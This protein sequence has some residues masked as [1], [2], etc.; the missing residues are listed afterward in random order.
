MDRRL[1]TATLAI[2]LLLAAL[3][4]VTAQGQDDGGGSTEAEG[5]A[6]TVFDV[7][8][9]Q[10]IDSM[11]PLIGVTVAAYEA[12]NLQYATLTDKAADDFSV[13]P[14][15][16]ESWEGSDDGKTWTYKLRPNLKWSDGEPLTAEDI[17]WNDQHLARRGVAQPLGDHHQPDG[18]GA[19]R[20][21]RRHQ[22]EGA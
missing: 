6:Q 8:D 21:H 2:A 4:A 19:G 17:V 13:I 18:D 20:H 22:V 14:G 9:P 16:A 5:G 3:T 12:W 10:G 1:L 7:G 15:L 11:S